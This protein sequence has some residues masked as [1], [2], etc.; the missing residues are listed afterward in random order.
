LLDGPDCGANVDFL[1]L[2]SDKRVLSCSFATGGVPFEAPQ[3]IRDIW[4]RMQAQRIAA[5]SPG[6]ARLPGFGR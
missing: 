4:Q 5:T 2:T 6:C 3:E 1:S